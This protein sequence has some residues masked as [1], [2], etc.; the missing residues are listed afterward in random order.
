MSQEKPTIAV[1]IGSGSVKC[2]AALGM[3]SA[4]QD[5]GIGVDLVVGC[6]AGAIFASLIAMGLDAEESADYTRRMWTREL[7]QTRR[8]KEF[9]KIVLPKQFGFDER[10]GIADD[11]L[12]VKRLEEAFGH[13]TFSDM[14]IPLYI[15]A[16]DFHTGEQVTLESGEIRH[17]IRASVSIPFTFKP[18]QIGDRMLVDGFLSDPLPVGVAMSQGANIIL[19][20]GFESPFQSNVKNVGRFAFQMSSIMSNN[21]LK[22]KLAFHTAAHHTEVIP[23][24][25]DFKERVRLFDTSKIPYVVEEGRQAIAPHIPYLKRLMNTPM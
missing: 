12:I 23:V 11:A 19:A 6:S 22:A 2:A 10:F 9:L 21:L 8:M 18:V 16:T 7:T 20:M 4:L 25:P 5:E 1:V 13:A 3:L 14:K 17:A 15:T 24:I